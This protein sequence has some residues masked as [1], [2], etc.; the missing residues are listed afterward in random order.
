MSVDSSFLI[1]YIQSGLR[2]KFFEDSTELAEAINLHASGTYP[3]ELIGERRPAESKQ[4]ADYREKIFVPMTKPV[5]AKVYNSL[6]K[7]QRSPDYAILY[8]GEVPARIPEM[9][10]LKQY[11]TYDIPHFGS[12]SNW[13]WSVAFRYYL[14][15]ANSWVLTLPMSWDSP[16]NEY[17]RPVPRVITSESVIDYR[18]GEYFV[19]LLNATERYEDENMNTWTDGMK[20]MVLTNDSIQEFEYAPY[21]RS[22]ITELYNRPN[23][24]GYIPIRSMRGI[25]IEQKE[26]Y[27]LYESRI[28]GIVPMLDE[29]VREYS[30]MQAEIVQHIHSTMWTIQPQQCTRCKGIGSY[31][32][33]EES[34]PVRCEVCKGQGI[35]PLNPYEH[36]SIP[37]PK[38]GENAVP[39]PPIGYVEKN[40]DIARLQEERIRQHIKDALDSIHMGFLADVPLSQSGVA[41][42]VDRE[43][44]Y[45]TVYSVAADSCRIISD[46]YYDVNQWRYKP[47]GFTDKEL[48]EM[49]PVVTIPERYDLLSAGVLVEE[50]T[51]MSAAKVDPAIIN[52]AQV[53]LAEK[54]F[55]TDP[56]VRDKVKLKLILDPFAGVPEESITMMN[57]LGAISKVD[58]VVHANINEFVNVAM[59]E[60]KGFAE[61]EYQKQQDI[62][63]RLATDK[64]G[65]MQSD[66]IDIEPTVTE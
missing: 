49:L 1:P 35:A 65:S 16:D 7:I 12:L 39:T 50:L 19:I 59:K 48:D 25:C 43:E 33:N 60:N 10:T 47:A 20:F 13:Y 28:A 54:R 15:D 27:N 32:P 2:H 52:A 17:Y 34:L 21:K 9:E 56:T 62:I 66:M 11:T 18:E 42:Q 46:I 37:M 26:G 61:L 57:A 51:A 8:D 40:T 45:S 22:A 30:D 14:I 31:R 29:A 64:L 5:F 4:I 55:A 58:L 53:D 63:A 24:L 6:Q 38:A 41:K 44:L 3:D 23:E 36:L